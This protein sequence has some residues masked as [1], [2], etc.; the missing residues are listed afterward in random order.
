MVQTTK[1]T[2]RNKL[3]KRLAAQVGSRPL[4]ENLL[5]KR[6]HLT[7][8]GKLTKAGETRNSMTAAERA[9]DRASKKSNKPT[10]AYKYDVKTNQATLKKGR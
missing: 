9:K 1:H 7:T 6:G 8:S 4:A 5:K 2:G 10:D 3:V